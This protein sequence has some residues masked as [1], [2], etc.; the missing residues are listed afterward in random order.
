MIELKTLVR[1]IPAVVPLLAVLLAAGCVRLTQPYV[2]TTFYTLEYPPPV[3]SDLQPLPVTLRLERFA[4]SPVYDTDRIIYRDR[5]HTRNAYAY[6]RWRTRPGNLVRDLLLRDLTRS[7]LFQAVVADAIGR[8]DYI[9]T[10]I[11]E[12]ILEWDGEGEFQAVLTV[13]ISLL[14]GRGVNDR[15]LLQRTFSARKPSASRDPHAV[16][17]AMS[18]A[19]ASIS[20]HIVRDLHAAILVHG[21]KTP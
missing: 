5:A 17:E 16:V 2:E 11:I 4:V 3:F 8:S 21:R 19:M 14:E 10:G 15:V 20:E 9:L 6:H 13:S 7:N 18:Q 12:E 1:K